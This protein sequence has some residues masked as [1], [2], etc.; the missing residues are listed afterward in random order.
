MHNLGLPGMVLKPTR[1]W[2]REQTHERVPSE[3]TWHPFQEK[4]E[5]ISYFLTRNQQKLYGK[6]IVFLVI[7]G[8]DIPVYCIWVFPKTDYMPLPEVIFKDYFS[9]ASLS[10]GGR[11]WELGWKIS[12]Q[13]EL[14][15]RSF[16]TFMS[17]KAPLDIHNLP[18]VLEKCLEKNKIC[19]GWKQPME[20]G[21][22]LAPLLLS[23][24]VNDIPFQP[25][26][27]LIT[28]PWNYIIWVRSL[29]S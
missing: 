6:T 13:H 14:G 11:K 9:P 25:F 29:V 2:S 19:S 3:T 8:Q 18:H 24:T 5:V 16:W 15:Y 26:P 22:N 23:C 20:M 1:D 7:S 28:E 12:H 10:T 27:S 17:H 4:L 21:R